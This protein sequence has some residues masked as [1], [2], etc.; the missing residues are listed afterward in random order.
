MLAGFVDRNTFYHTKEGFPQ[1]SPISPTL[2]NMVLD[3]LQELCYENDCLFA[4][5]ADDFYVPGKSEEEL[6]ALIPK[7]AEFLAKRGLQLSN[8]KTKITNITGL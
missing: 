8:S 4:R 1:G 7:I 3:G 6:K 5:Y 2:A